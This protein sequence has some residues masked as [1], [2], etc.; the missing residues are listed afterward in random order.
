MP[1]SS[2]HLQLAISS[3]SSAAATATTA[4]TECRDLPNG[5]SLVSLATPE[6]ANTPSSQPLRLR[7]RGRRGMGAGPV[8]ADRRHQLAAPA[9]R[10][11]FPLS[12]GLPYF[13]SY[14]ILRKAHPECGVCPSTF[15]PGLYTQYV[16][17]TEPCISRCARCMRCA[18]RCTCT[19]NY[20]T[21]SSTLREASSRITSMQTAVSA[22]ERR[23]RKD[24]ST[25][26]ALV[27]AID[28]SRG[29]KHSIETSGICVHTDRRIVLYVLVPYSS[30]DYTTNMQ[31]ILDLPHSPGN[32]PSGSGTPPA[33]AP[34]LVATHASVLSPASLLPHLLHAAPTA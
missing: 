5:S 14:R 32:P 12:N 2:E 20:G 31:S 9:R 34:R 28:Q 11:F 1:P 30:V 10:C 17:S 29:G 23:V 19:Q 25:W 16:N 3:H 13:W 8:N 27:H 6:D 21:R 15:G 26:V 4:C 33:P 7:P 24:E 22:P 18:S